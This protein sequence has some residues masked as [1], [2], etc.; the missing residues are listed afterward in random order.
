MKYLLGILFFTFTLSVFA[1]ELVV[2]PEYPA[3][4]K[5][6]YAY[7]VEVT[8]GDVT[9]PLV[10]YNHT[11]S[12][13]LSGRQHGGD[14]QRR[15]CEFAFS[16]S[17]VRVDVAVQQDVASYTVFP[18]SARLKTTFKKNVISVYLD[19]PVYFGI[20]LNDDAN[21]ILSVFPDAPETDVPQKD[22]PDVMYVDSW[23]DAPDRS[24]VIT[25]DASVKEIWFYP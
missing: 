17:P 23:T 8:Q 22:A 24:G 9:K 15:F 14:S 4:I 6:D 16:G 7:A 19:R 12:S 21:T 5:R 13:I 1:D 2:Y 20:R 3:Q 11:E 10:V 25:T 18:A